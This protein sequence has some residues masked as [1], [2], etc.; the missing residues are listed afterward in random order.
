MALEFQ[1]VC[2]PPPGVS[3]P[4]VANLSAAEVAC[5]NLGRNG[6]TPLLFE[7]DPSAPVGHCLASW[8]GRNG[9]LRVI[10]VVT[11]PSMKKSVLNGKNRGLSLGTDIIQDTS[12]NASDGI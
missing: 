3:P 5:T 9:E 6:G 10:G 11:D 1:G 4:D 12:G 2:H 8:E 7:H